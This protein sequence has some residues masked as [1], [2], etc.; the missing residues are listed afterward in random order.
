MVSVSE[1]HAGMRDADVLKRAVKEK[2]IILTFDRD[3]G[4]LIFKH[5]KLIPEGL[6]YFR[7]DPPTPAEPAIILINIMRQKNINFLGHF[8]VIEEDKI[9]QRVL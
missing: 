8:T 3:Y 7:F 5:P 9:R 6:V 4:A 2:S 1:E